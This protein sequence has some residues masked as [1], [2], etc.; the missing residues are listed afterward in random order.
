VATCFS[1]LLKYCTSPP[2][3]LSVLVWFPPFNSPGS[4]KGADIPKNLLPPSRPSPRI[5][6]PPR[7]YPPPLLPPRTLQFLRFGNLDMCLEDAPGRLAFGDRQ[8]DKP[9]D[10]AAVG[11]RALPAIPHLPFFRISFF[12]VY[13][14]LVIF[15]SLA[16]PALFFSGW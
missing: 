2:S 5:R 8:V 1:L 15:F 11:T 14:S 10:L 3:S 16:K 9:E 6:S 7:S 12:L 4:R 13:A